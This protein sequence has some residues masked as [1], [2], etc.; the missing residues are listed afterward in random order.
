MLKDII[1]NGFYYLVDTKNKSEKF[2]PVR[3]ELEI[4]GRKNGEIFYYDK[5]PNTVT[6][7]AKHSMMHILTGESFSNQGRQRSLSLADHQKTAG[8]TYINN[9]GTLLSNSQYFDTPVFPGTMGWWSKGDSNLPSAST[10]IYPYFPT[11]MLFGTGFEWQNQ[12]LIDA[13]YWAY[14]TTIAGGSWSASQFNN[15]IP[16]SSNDYSANFGGVSGDSILP[17]KSMNDI[18]ST[19]L[20]T[21]IVVDTDFGIKGAIK[22]GTYRNNKGDSAKLQ[23]ISG[24]YFLKNDYAGIGKPSFI[25]CKRE[26]RFYQAGTE[27]ALDFDTNV[28][29]KITYTITMPEQTGL[30]AG[31]FY[32]YNGFTLKL[33]GL[34]CDSRF[35]L[36]N[37]VPVDDAHSQDVALQER[38]NYLKMPHGILIAKR[39]IAPITKS[40]NVSITARWTMY[41]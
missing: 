32:P 12:A 16:N 30:N 15:N 13:T 40:H 18:Y 8:D 21:P 28:E 3:G 10:Y 24:D 7:W 20:I 4:I 39:Y 27:I 37:D 35:M 22:D 29:N 14:Y 38:K 34:F 26:S 41:I 33:A 17:C 5:G 19:A 23:I 25:Y 2:Y 9:D 11:K 6:V 31:K 1:K 36:E